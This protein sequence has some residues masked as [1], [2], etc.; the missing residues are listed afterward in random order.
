MVEFF[1]IDLFSD[2]T[3]KCIPTMTWTL[4]EP[5]VYFMAACMPTLRPLK[6][7]VFNDFS[8]MS[9]ITSTIGRISTRRS[10]SRGTTR[11]S[12]HDGSKVLKTTDIKLESTWAV[13]EDA[14]TKS[15]DPRASGF[16]RMEEYHIPARGGAFSQV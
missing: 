10:T 11:V 16:V 5:G 12:S 15:L 6:R 1:T 7:K 4:V 3:F 13:S 8:F 9:L 2:P 14:S